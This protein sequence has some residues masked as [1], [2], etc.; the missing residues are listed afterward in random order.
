MKRIKRFWVL[1]K[2][3][4]FAK[5]TDIKLENEI[6]YQYDK[7]PGKFDGKYDILNNTLIAVFSS[8]A[9]NYLLLDGRLVDLTKDIT[10]GHRIA[11]EMNE[12]SR[13]KVYSKGEAIYELEYINP[14]EPMINPTPF[15]T[16]EDYG[17]TNFACELG[18]YI[19]RVQED[20]NVVLFPENF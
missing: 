15:D 1:D 4:E 18:K 17:T 3:I 8:D 20:S 14:H 11:H 13:F 19:R 12:I 5:I 2:C 16:H 7:P 10:I 6:G 9:R